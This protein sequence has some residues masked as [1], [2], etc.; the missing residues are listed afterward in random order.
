MIVAIN[1]PPSCVVV[2]LFNVLFLGRLRPWFSVG[3][4]P[5]RL[6]ICPGGSVSYCN[7]TTAFSVLL[8]KDC[9]GLHRHKNSRMRTAGILRRHIRPCQY[10]VVTH[11]KRHRRERQ[12]RAAC[13][14]HLCRRLPAWVLDIILEHFFGFVKK[15]NHSFCEKSSYNLVTTSF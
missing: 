12:K 15:T 7:G 10:S 2:G 4:L 6:P 8:P 3:I 11:A 14:A 9:C 5:V 13:Q 1:R